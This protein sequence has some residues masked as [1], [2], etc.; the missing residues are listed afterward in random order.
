[1]KFPA[2]IALC[3]IGGCII[4]AGCGSAE[5][6][7]A[8]TTPAVEPSAPVAPAP[9]SPA[10]ETHAPELAD[11]KQ[12]T[13]EVASFTPPFP[14]R[15]DMFAVKETQGNVRRDDEKGE[16]VELKGF[17]NVDQPR[18]ILSIDGVISPVPEGGE[19]YGVQV[20][21]ITPPSVVLKRGRDR[22][23]AKLE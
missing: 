16:S 1:M 22:W 20:L 6:P 4:V 17:I 9:P 21:S 14:E 5:Q 3:L 8:E 15:H 2:Q 23:T 7:I 19:K 10:S 18:V 11:P 13:A 12:T